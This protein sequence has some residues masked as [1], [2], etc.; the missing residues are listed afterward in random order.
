MSLIGDE[1]AITVSDPPAPRPRPAIDLVL[2]N[3]SGRAEQARASDMTAANPGIRA[4]VFDFGGVLI[5]SIANQIGK[6]ASTHG[7]EPQLMHE[8]LLG[9]RISSPSH[10]WHRAE[11]GEIAVADIQLLLQP[12]ATEVGFDLHGDEIDRVLAPGEYTVVNE[13]V[14]RVRSLRAAGYLTGL[15]TN[16]FAEFRPTMKRDIDFELFD[17]VVE[18]FAVGARK[19]ELAIY[20]AT[21]TTLGVPHHS[22]LY[23]DDFDQNLVPPRQLGWTTIHVDDPLEAIGRLGVVLGLPPSSESVHS[24]RDQFLSAIRPE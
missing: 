16:T 3:S 24:S 22:I 5:T 12:W 23:L 19:P 2:R 21:A 1:A 18:S 20:E 13:M 17:V 14:D 8:V 9:P 11:R 6:I 10:P 7:V 4:I 15:L